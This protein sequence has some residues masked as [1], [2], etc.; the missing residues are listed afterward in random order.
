MSTFICQSNIR[1]KAYAI[2]YQVTK[3]YLHFQKYVY[4]G[5]H[6]DRIPGYMVRELS[7]GICEWGCYNENFSYLWNLNGVIEF[8]Q[9]E[10]EARGLTW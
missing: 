2:G 5:P 3:G 4:R 1:R 9:E 8:L 10:Y 7:T 6:G